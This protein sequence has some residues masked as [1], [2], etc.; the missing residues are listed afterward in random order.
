MPIA[1]GRPPVFKAP[2]ANEAERERVDVV[3]IMGTAPLSLAALGP[4]PLGLHEAPQ[5]RPRTAEVDCSFAMAQHARVAQV[6][7]RPNRWPEE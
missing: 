5:A 4:P 7:G 3:S 1:R 2:S 6:Q